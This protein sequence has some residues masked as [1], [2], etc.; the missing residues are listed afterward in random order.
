[1]FLVTGIFFEKLK[2]ANA[3]V[4]GE[5]VLD[6]YQ[7]KYPVIHLLLKDACADSFPS[8]KEKLAFALRRA[9]NEHEYLRE[10][11]L[12][13]G[14]ESLDFFN[15]IMASHPSN[16]EMIDSLR[17]LSEHLYKHYSKPVYVLIDEYDRPV[18]CVLEGYLHDTHNTTVRGQMK[19]TSTFITNMMSKVGKLNPY[20]KKM[21]LTGILDTIFR[22]D[23][24]GLNNLEHYDVLDLKFSTSFGF[25]KEEVQALLSVFSFDNPDHI[26]EDIEFWYNGYRTGASATKSGTQ[27]FIP[28]S[29]AKQHSSEEVG[30][31]V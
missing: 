1:M 28:F 16:E 18:S 3:T 26:L 2:I 20:L 30:I 29:V 19:A 25:S 9:F 4:G 11:K 17:F 7:G 13:N 5:T 15:N 22:E 12:R 23:S 14:Q 10:G 27:S 21:V 8:F 6:A 24:S 31:T